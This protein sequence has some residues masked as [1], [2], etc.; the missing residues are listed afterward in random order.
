MDYQTTDPTTGKTLECYPTATGAECRGAIERAAAAFAAWRATPVEARAERLRRCAESLDRQAPELAELMAVEMGKPLVEGE[1]E[2]AKCAWGCRFFAEQA[3]SFL[4]PD[5]KDSDG[6]QA[7]VRYD[8]LGP[9]LAIMPWNFPFWQFF[10][11]AAPALMAGNVVLLKHAP[12][13]PGCARRIERLLGESGLPDGVVQNLFLTDEQAAGVIADPRVRG[14]TLTGSTR[15][16]RQVAAAAGRQLKAMVMELGGSD[17]F[18]VFGDAD[19]ER[20]ADTAVASRCLN[21]GQS[22]IAAKRFLVEASVFDRFRDAVVERMRSRKIGD[23]RDRSV[24]L[25][26]L[27]RRDLRD[28]LADQVD[29]TVAAGARVLCGGEPPARDGFFYPA[30]VLVDIPAGSPAAREELFGP[31]ASLFPFDDE[32]QAVALANDSEYGLGASLWTRERE[33]VDRLIPRLDSG[34]V[35]VNG[36]VKSDPRL[37]FGGVKQSGFGRELSREGMLEFVNRKTVWIA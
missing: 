35:F 34:S 14:V 31:V 26:P 9:L 36:L 10:R 17:P 1:A 24:E 28:T 3:A 20:A 25:G 6:S 19:L 5:A 12:N 8:P 33:R 18:I 13:T 15:A 32:R 37:P 27:A 21:N 29:R 22:C 11:F 7:Y 16:G 30:T 4:E 2:A 23:P